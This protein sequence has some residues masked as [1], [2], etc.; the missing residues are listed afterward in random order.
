MSL[1]EQRDGSGPLLLDRGLSSP[2]GTKPRLMQGNLRYEGEMDDLLSDL[3]PSK[4]YRTPAEIRSIPNEQWE[5]WLRGNN[6]PF[7]SFSAAA[8]CQEVLRTIVRA[9]LKRMEAE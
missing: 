2:S 4:R 9:T 5:T 1:A 7:T 6:L 3:S 8:D